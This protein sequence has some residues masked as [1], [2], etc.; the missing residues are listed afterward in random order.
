MKKLF[1]FTNAAAFLSVSFLTFL[2][3]VLYNAEF[4]IH[5]EVYT[6][7]AEN[8]EVIL[9]SLYAFAASL[10]LIATAFKG[11]KQ[12][13]RNILNRENLMENVSTGFDTCNGPHCYQ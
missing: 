7:P 1:N 5:K 4:V 9:F 2:G 3:Y 10:F 8:P 13:K 6:L 11:R 12:R